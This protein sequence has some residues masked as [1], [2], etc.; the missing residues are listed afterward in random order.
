[1]RG[2]VKLEADHL[3]Q[4]IYRVSAQDPRHVLTSRNSGVDDVSKKV[5][6]IA[7]IQNTKLSFILLLEKFYLINQR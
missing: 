4:Y 1:M 3:T 6:Y 2:R 5:R 7:K